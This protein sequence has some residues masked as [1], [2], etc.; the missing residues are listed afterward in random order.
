MK[1]ILNIALWELKQKFSKRA[2]LYVTVI[3][4]LIL[5]FLVKFTTGG[6]SERSVSP[7]TLGLI[8]TESSFINSFRSLSFNFGTYNNPQPD[9]I[10]VN[11]GNVSVSNKISFIDSIMGKSG[12]DYILFKDENSYELISR[13]FRRPSLISKI[14]MFTSLASVNENSLINFSGNKIRISTLDLNTGSEYSTVDFIK[15]TVTIYLLPIIFIFVVVFAGNSFIRGFAQERQGRIIEILLS[16]CSRN[17][18]F[19]GKILGLLLVTVVHI[20]IW[21]AVAKLFLENNFSLLT[22]SPALGGLFFTLGFLLYTALFIGLSG[23]ITTENEAQHISSNL[24]LLLVVPLVFSTHVIASPQSLLSQ[25]LSYFPLTSPPVMLIKIQLEAVSINELI[26]SGA[27]L[28]V[29]CLVLIKLAVK[30]FNNGLENLP[31]T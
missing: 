16:S 29:S 6:V 14:E 2:Y 26:I 12:V 13:Y 15:N 27:I 3:T 4:P 28:L 18:L 5:I 20:F 9:I 1:N 17:Q 25:I 8:N 19:Y 24:S 30:Y 7:V 11:L 21:W 22:T 23:L 10:P 31:N